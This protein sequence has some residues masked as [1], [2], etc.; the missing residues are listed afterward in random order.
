MEQ[1]VLTSISV[2]SLIENI[3]S[4]TAQI[5][6][7]QKND[8]QLNQSEDLLSRKQALE[9]LQITSATLWRWEKDGKIK[10]HGIG[11]KRYYKRSEL[12]ESLIEKK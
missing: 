2:N 12:E 6:Q 1:I 4:R 11:S 8:S 10:S 7:N 3:A 9:L 5:L